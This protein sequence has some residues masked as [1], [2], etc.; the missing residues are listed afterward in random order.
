MAALEAAR[1]QPGRW[2][3]MEAAARKELLSHLGCCRRRSIAKQT[4]LKTTCRLQVHSVEYFAPERF[5]VMKTLQVLRVDN[6]RIFIYISQLFPGF[7]GCIK[8]K[9][10]TPLMM[11][12]VCGDSTWQVRNE[13]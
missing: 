9:Y 4:A 12:G 3:V 1:Q 7:F 5:M 13:S 10:N 2:K 11:N 6:L 8:H